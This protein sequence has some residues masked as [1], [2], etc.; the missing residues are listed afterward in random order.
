MK[1]TLFDLDHTLLGGDSDALWCDFLMQHGVLEREH[2]AA[3]NADMEARYRSGTV[4]TQEFSNFYI[5]TLAGR[6]RQ[7][8]EPLRQLFLQTQIIPRIARPALDLVKQHLDE[9]ALVVMTTAT[10]RFLT[11]LTAQYLHI[12]HLIATELEMQHDRFSGR[13]AGVLNMREGKVARLH[14]WLQS[15]GRRLDDFDSTAYS[16]SINDLAL[17]MAVNRAVAVNPDTQLRAKAQQLGWKIMEWS[18]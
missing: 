4:G 12:E 14:D 3:R 11:E 15:S 10:N 9:G 7:Q 2:F 13:S 1:L 17:L 5:S 18:A 6:T 8:C 16:D